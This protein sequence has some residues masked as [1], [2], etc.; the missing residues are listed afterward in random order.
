MRKMKLHL[1]TLVVE[2]FE[3]RPRGRGSI[4]TVRAH[5]SGTEMTVCWGECGGGDSTY[6][7]CTA[8]CGSGEE[9]TCDKTCVTCPAS[10]DGWHTCPN[11]CADS[12]WES[13]GYDCP[14]INSPCDN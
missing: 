11:T 10:C 4:G 1:D 14:S 6:A 9:V 5:D 13:C 12:C 7:L 3:T 8:N 2:S